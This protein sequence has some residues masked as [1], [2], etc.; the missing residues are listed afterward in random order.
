MMIPSS[1]PG[2]L[3][4]NRYTRRIV[5]VMGL[6]MILSVIGRRLR[7]AL[8]GIQL[9]LEAN[10][11]ISNP[12]G[13]AQSGNRVVDIVIHQFQQMRQFGLC[14]FAN[15]LIYIVGEDEIQE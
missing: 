12:L 5:L 11:N 3:L 2:A 1:L 10:E 15:A 4:S 8:A 9:R 7:R 6:G 14:E 13:A